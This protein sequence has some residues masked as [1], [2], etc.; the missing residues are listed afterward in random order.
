VNLDKTTRVVDGVET[1]LLEG[2]SG[3]PLLYLHAGDGLE[4]AEPLVE[5]LAAN[6][7]VYAPSHPGFGGSA[8]PTRISSVD[9]LAYFYL[10]LMDDL[11]FDCGVVMGVSFGGWIAAEI[12]V[13]NT[14]RLSHLVL[15]AP[16]GAKFGDRESRGI[17]DL[18]VMTDKE[19]GERLY[20]NPKPPPDYPSMSEDAVERAVRNRESFTFFS[21]SP[22]LYNPKLRQRLH[23]I[24]VPTLLLW[25]G[26]DRVLASG[27][28]RDFENEIAAAHSHVI[29]GAGHYLHSDCPAELAAAVANFVAPQPAPSD[30]PR[31]QRATALGG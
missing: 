4:A 18:F 27:Y 17:A 22:T 12:A 14:S 29:A 21:W 16:V 1:E 8:L 10:D 19:L 7:R 28:D 31:R 6:F 2:G 26:E 9:D 13:R 24:N 5:R 20:A 3:A 25:G 23:R 11:D 30:A 15:G